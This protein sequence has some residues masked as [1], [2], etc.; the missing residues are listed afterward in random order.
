MKQKRSLPVWRFEVQHLNTPQAP[1][2]LS[3][4]AR[5]R[6]ARLYLDI[7]NALDPSAKV[8]DLGSNPYAQIRVELEEGDPRLVEILTL[9]KAAGWW[10]H[11]GWQADVE[12]QKFAVQRLWKPSAKVINSAPFLW[13]FPFAIVANSYGWEQ[14]QLRLGATDNALKNKYGFGDA[15]CGLYVVS[16]EFRQAYEAAKLKGA[17]FHPVVWNNP[18]PRHRLPYWL[19]STVELPEPLTKL[20]PTKDLDGNRMWGW[21]D[22]GFAPPVRRFRRSEIAKLGEF[23]VAAIPRVGQYV[24]NRLIPELVF[25]QRFREFVTRGGWKMRWQPGGFEDE[26]TNVMAGSNP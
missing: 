15:Y 1:S 24:D 12:A 19:G 23:D 3:D 20:Y 2:Y 8:G 13:G 21:D 17:V 6:D 11:F 10:P 16:E 25:S 9:L 26:D 22:N 14:G 4:G 7:A 5:L 18:Q